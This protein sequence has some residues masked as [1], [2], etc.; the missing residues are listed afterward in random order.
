MSNTAPFHSKFH[1]IA[2][3]DGPLVGR[4]RELVRLR[5]LC[6]QP[7]TSIVVIQGSAGSGKTRLALE[8]L[9]SWRCSFAWSFQSEPGHETGRVSADSF[10]SEL[11]RYLGEEPRAHESGWDRTL[12]IAERLKQQR[13]L[14]VLDGAELLQQPETGE[15]LDPTLKLLVSSLSEGHSGQCL[16]TTRIPVRTNKSSWV[17]SFALGNLSAEAGAS[18]LKDEGVQANESEL[19]DT[20]LAVRGHAFSLKLV[21]G[22]VGK[23]RRGKSRLTTMLGDMSSPWA[24]R[25]TSDSSSSWAVLGSLL[26]AHDQSF[27][28]GPESALLRFM[29]VLGSTVRRELLHQLLEQ[30]TFDWRFHGLKHLRTTD[31]DEGISRLRSHSL[32]TE[33]E[34]ERFLLHPIVRDYFREQLRAE[35]PEK[36]RVLHEYLFEFFRRKTAR[37]PDKTGEL[38]PLYQAFHSG[39]LGG[40]AE[41]SFRDVFWERLRRGHQDYSTR[42]LGNETSDAIALYGYLRN[43]CRP[44]EQEPLTLIR[45]ALEQAMSRFWSIGWTDDAIRT[46]WIRFRLEREKGAIEAAAALSV[47]IEFL[48]QSGDLANAHGVA[49]LKHQ[50]AEQAKDAY[51]L[52]K[53]KSQLARVLHRR[54]LLESALSMF[55]SA[56]EL[57]T[58]DEP[59][60]PLLQELDGLFFCELLLDLGEVEQSTRRMA[61]IIEQMGELRPEE[62]VVKNL[63]ITRILLDSGKPSEA[64]A[65][66][67]EALVLSKEISSRPLELQ[68]LLMRATCYAELGSSH[69]QEDL[70]KVLMLS[71][72]LNLKLIHSDARL[73]EAH[74]TLQ[75]DPARGKEQLRELR[76]TLDDLDYRL[77]IPD[78]LMEEARL[79]LLESDKELAREFFQEASRLVETMPCRS[80]EQRLKNLSREL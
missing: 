25:Y 6:A 67:E 64:L 46:A 43:D 66:L 17:K 21:G 2:R 19:L 74:V 8:L 23:F 35:A 45:S 72:C 60:A 7:R 61:R 69:V 41:A 9:R 28:A 33:T 68:T 31:I 62:D 12:R 53:S 34:D 51:L 26:Q 22:L 14:L 5:E 3:P 57:N 1:D 27:E 79:A 36:Y 47:L 11:L 44:S 50:L 49:L 75:Q 18:M 71:S 42:I 73:L 38:L 29:A 55:L 13:I 30:P 48:V 80:R 54:G 16:I 59:E 10:A 63:L 70:K 24:L 39:Y 77:K 37:R 58:R 78:L 52:V 65:L 76:A 32:L 15:F 40:R 56:E 20:A 4:Q